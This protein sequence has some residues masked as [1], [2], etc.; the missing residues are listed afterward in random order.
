MEMDYDR[1]KENAGGSKAPKVASGGLSDLESALD[2]IQRAK[3]ME[4]RLQDEVGPSLSE[5]VLELAQD[6]K[7]QRAAREI[8]Y[9]PEEA[10]SGPASGP[11]SGSERGEV[12]PEVTESAESGVTSLPI[13]PIKRNLGAIDDYEKIDRIATGRGALELGIATTDTGSYRVTITDGD[14]IIQYP[15]EE[16]IEW[17]EREGLYDRSENTENR[18]QKVR[19]RLDEW[20]STTRE[21]VVFTLAVHEYHG[22]SSLFE[23]QEDIADFLDTSGSNVRN[24]KSEFSGATI[25]IFDE[26]EVTL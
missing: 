25:T 20:F 1:F 24:I 10:A 21:K 8:W 3:E 19:K 7:I 9:G 6:P 18:R 16:F 15:A 5:Q 4:R 23:S 2:Q 22:E 26:I 17:A 13:E 12:T 14:E 11:A